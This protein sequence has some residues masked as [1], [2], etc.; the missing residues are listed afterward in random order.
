MIQLDPAK[1]GVVDE[2]LSARNAERKEELV[3]IFLVN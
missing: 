1:I 2:N 3:S